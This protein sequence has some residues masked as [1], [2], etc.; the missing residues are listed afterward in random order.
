MQIARQR[1]KWT[2]SNRGGVRFES[3]ICS[4]QIGTSLDPDG[5]IR[6]ASHFAL[7]GQRT[8]EIGGNIDGFNIQLVDCRCP[9][10]HRQTENAPVFL[11][12]N[13]EQK[14]VQGGSCGSHSFFPDYFY[15]ILQNQSQA[16]ARTVQDSEHA[17]ITVLNK[18]PCRSGECGC[19]RH[20]CIDLPR[21][22]LRRL[23]EPGSQ[24]RLAIS[25]VSPSQSRFLTS[26]M[27]NYCQRVG[28]CFFF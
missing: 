5:T 18:L 3:P 26:R 15:T 24:T 8:S 13:E 11:S 19:M 14:P 23:S 22:M 17:S 16:R 25:F 27:N 7:A 6:R 21:P 9:P 1:D 2:V 4:P 10:L 12:C 20:R 28:M